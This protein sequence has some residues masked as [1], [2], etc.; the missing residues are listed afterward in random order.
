MRSPEI[1]LLFPLLD[2][3]H[4]ALRTIDAGDCTQPIPAR[5]LDMVSEA[6]MRIEAYCRAV[7]FRLG[8]FV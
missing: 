3:C 8:E 2:Q 1:P 4:R 5:D 6:V 7:G